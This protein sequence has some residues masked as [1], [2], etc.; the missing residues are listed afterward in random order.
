MKY[1]ILIDKRSKI[2]REISKLRK[3][4]S[5]ELNCLKQINL[6][7]TT[8]HEGEQLDMFDVVE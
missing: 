6:E 5:H 7:I 3:M 4:L 1:L 2:T 8:Y